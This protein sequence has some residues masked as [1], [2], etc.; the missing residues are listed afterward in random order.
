MKNENDDQNEIIVIV[1]Y[2]I[3]AILI[4]VPLIYILS[5]A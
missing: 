2:I 1:M 5:N 4:F 3:L